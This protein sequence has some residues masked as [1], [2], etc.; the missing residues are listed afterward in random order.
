MRR[1]QERVL[2]GPVADLGGSMQVPT[3]KS[4]TNRALIAAAVAGGGTVLEPLD[5]EDT[6]LLAQ[7]L[8]EAG[9]PVQWTA[10]K[11]QVGSRSEKTEE[12]RVH[13]GNSGTGARLILALLA[14]VPGRFVVDGTNRLR[15]RPMGP[16]IAGLEQL[17]A[18]LA[19]G[20]DGGLPVTVEGRSLDGGRVS[21][22]PEMSS[23]FVSALLLVA[24]SFCDGLTLVIEGPLPSAPY[25]ELT[26]VILDAFG[27]VF[28]HSKEF[29]EWEVSS[30]GL[31]KTS[32]QVEG[33]WSAAAFP[34]GA[35]AVAG[36][37]VEVRPLNK[38]SPQGDRVICEILGSAGMVIRFDGQSLVAGGGVRRPIFADL[39]ACPDAFPLLAAVSACRLPGSRLE[40][41]ANL[42]HKE[43]DRLQV[44]VDNLTSLG[45]RVRVEESRF[46]ILETVSRR[47]REVRLVTAAEDHRIAMAMAVTALAAG[48]LSLDNAE[49]VGK[50]FPDFWG[51]WTSLIGT[52][53]VDAK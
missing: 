44:M 45:A 28:R 32:Y 22:R 47:P 12:V 24:P 17:G 30:G 20:P 15:Q 1:S 13:L 48:P 38:R 49:C 29:R 18:Q 41:L 52:G 11:I 26:A 27:G 43:S 16:L 10:G 31:R 36:G 4:L 39:E 14:S 25:L 40:G 34:L 53:K 21:M 8:S 46:E 33:D 37:E 51:R 7:A 9:W 5:C 42:V 2:H 19:V 35:V 23:Q 50:S 6:R 3:S